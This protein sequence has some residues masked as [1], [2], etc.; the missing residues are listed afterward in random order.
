[1]IVAVLI[2]TAALHFTGKLT[3]IPPVITSSTSHEFQGPLVGSGGYYYQGDDGIRH[4]KNLT[5]PE[6]D[7]YIAI[8][9]GFYQLALRANGSIVCWGS[10]GLFGQCDVPKESDVIAVAG[11][12]EHGIALRSNGTIVCWG[13]QCGSE[14]QGDDFTAISTGDKLNLALRSNGTIVAWGNNQSGQEIVPV[15]NDFIAISAG[16][17]NG[18]ALRSNGTIVCWGAREYCDIPPGNDYVAISASRNSNLAITSEGE[19]IAWDP[20]IGW[21]HY[22]PP[23]ND[24]VAVS[25]S[26]SGYHLAL[27][28]NG[29]VVCWGETGTGICNISLLINT[30]A[31]SAGSSQSLAITNPQAKAILTAEWQKTKAR[32]K[33]QPVG[34]MEA[35]SW[36]NR[37]PVYPVTYVIKAALPEMQDSVM[38]YCGKEPITGFFPRDLV[39]DAKNVPGTYPYKEFTIKSLDEAIG[40]FKTHRLTVSSYYLHEHGPIST[41][42]AIIVTNISFGY[43]PDTL[44]GNKCLQPVFAFEGYVEK[45][46]VSDSFSTDLVP[47]TE[48][49]VE[50]DFTREVLIP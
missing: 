40:E 45:D 39:K 24:Y 6:G 27:R 48:N 37:T 21:N 35:R 31:I 44:A 7:D 46:G 3:G 11:G 5:V 13:R 43:T 14:P 2:V 20:F 10:N 23:G 8:S 29:S 1:M 17:Y 41:A 9:S 18:V 4:L 49:L 42:D 36:K 16:E 50:F 34:E 32:I 15:G 26:I 22:V 30:I 19:L 38:T 28:A 33:I 12:G 47:A 25:N